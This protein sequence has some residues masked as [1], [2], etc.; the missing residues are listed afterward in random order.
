M[1]GARHDKFVVGYRINAKFEKKV[2]T[3]KIDVILFF[4]ISFI[5]S[6]GF[7]GFLIMY[8]G[9]LKYNPENKSNIDMS[10]ENC[11]AIPIFCFDH[12]K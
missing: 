11:V 10:K 4:L 7:E 6:I 2:G 5:L 1:C 12:F 3:E 9:T 8:I